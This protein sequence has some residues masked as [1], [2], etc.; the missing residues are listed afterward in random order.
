MC[1][2]RARRQALVWLLVFL[3]GI[4]FVWSNGRYV[5]NFVQ[6]PFAIQPAALAQITDVDAAPEYFVS[7]NSDKVLDTG[8]QEI[9]TTTRNGAEESSYVSAGYYAVVLGNH[10]LIVKIERPEAMYICML[11]GIRGKSLESITSRNS[12]RVIVL[13]SKLQ[14]WS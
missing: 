14:R 2:K 4:V 8:I 6:G 1:R 11:D 5:R 3:G 9:T 7:V 10:F 12:G 13:P